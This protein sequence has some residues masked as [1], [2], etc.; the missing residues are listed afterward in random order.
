M[1]LYLNEKQAVLFLHIPKTAGTT[2]ETWLENSGKFE[3]LL[4]S[5]KKP[6]DLNV[7]PQHLGY[8]TLAKLTHGIKRP[9]E[10]KFAIVRNPFDRLVSEFFY[11]TKLN[12]INLGN[13]PEDL[14]SSWVVHNLTKYK[15]NKSI[16]DNHLRPQSYYVDKDVQIFK[17]EDGIQNIINTIGKALEIDVNGQIEAKKVSEKKEVVWDKSSVRLVLETYAE[18]FEKFEYSKESSQL[19]TSQSTIRSFK[20]NSLYILYA[21]K[22]KV[23]N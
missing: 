21:L 14:F 11:R 9:I 15:R 7:T 2:I 23:S 16:F 10:Y 12:N 1:P 4:F 19:K 6:D 22:R 5:Q 20:A 18:D 3:Q 17:F 8:D 13:S